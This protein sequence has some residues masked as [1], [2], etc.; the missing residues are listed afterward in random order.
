MFPQER[1]LSH[2]LRRFSPAS[3]ISYL[4]Y[5]QERSFFN[6][7][8]EMLGPPWLSQ[9]NFPSMS[10]RQKLNQSQGYERWRYRNEYYS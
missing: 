9:D 5:H 3:F 2:K 6:W 7:K 8:E 10:G 1:E 4:V